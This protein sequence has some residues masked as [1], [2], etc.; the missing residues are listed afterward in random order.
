MKR[1]QPRRLTRVPPEVP[2][3]GY[4]EMPDQPR[5]PPATR[6]YRRRAGPA[7]GTARPGRRAGAGPGWPGAAPPTGTVRARAPAPR[8]GRTAARLPGRTRCRWVPARGLA[9]RP[10]GPDPGGTDP[11]GTE[12]DGTDP[13]DP[14]PAAPA[15]DVP[16]G[17]PAAGC[18]PA[19]A[20]A[21]PGGDRPGPPACPEPGRRRARRG[22]G[23]GRARAEPDRHRD[24]EGIADHGRGDEGGQGGRARR[25]AP[26]SG[27]PGAHGGLRDVPGHR[28][29]DPADPQPRPVSPPRGAD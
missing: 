22:R 10:D 18:V 2:V 19:G 20:L 17:P 14:E 8:A 28:E 12:P 21:P 16:C 15:G 29:R 4:P 11:G 24:E 9:A 27:Q 13:E 1:I 25:M 26:D 5:I 3:A 23:P 7:G 6:R